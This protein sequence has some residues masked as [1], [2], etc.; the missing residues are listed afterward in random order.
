MIIVHEVLTTKQYGRGVLA[1]VVLLIGL[2]SPIYAAGQ[3]HWLFSGF[4]YDFTFF[5]SSAS[6]LE[7]LVG[8]DNIAYFNSL[9]FDVSWYG[10]LGQDSN[11]GM[12][13]SLGFLFPLDNA[14]NQEQSLGSTPGEVGT[15][16]KMDFIFSVLLGP[17]FRFRC[18]DKLAMYLGVGL[19]FAHHTTSETNTQDQT[20]TEGVTSFG[21]GLDVGFKLDITNKVCFR[22]GVSGSYDFATL[23]TESMTTNDHQNDKY[24]S[25][26]QITNG[27]SI[28]PYIG[29]GVVIRTVQEQVAPRTVSLAA[30][31]LSRP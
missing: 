21:G 30:L 1:V 29:M 23:Y 9:G 25:T 7:S 16:H 6:E 26:F 5:S 17:A 28:R 11:V 8:D 2:A 20:T 19:S 31:S 3:E 24:S 12:Y 27:F 4:D 18:T 10:F 15:T 13:T 14:K 22:A